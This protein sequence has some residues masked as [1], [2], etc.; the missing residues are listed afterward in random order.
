MRLDAL[1]N[2]VAYKV[3]AGK[4]TAIAPKGTPPKTYG[5]N[6]SVTNFDDFRV[7]VGRL[8]PALPAGNGSVTALEKKSRCAKSAKT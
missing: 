8:S 2:V 4:R 3:E 6:H 5:V 7:E 1:N